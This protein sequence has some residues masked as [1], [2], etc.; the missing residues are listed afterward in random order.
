M[1]WYAY[2]AGDY[3]QSVAYLQ[4]AFARRPA[5]Q[6]VG[7][8]LGYAYEALGAHEIENFVAT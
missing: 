7:L 5:D 2:Q 8:R 3:A 1:G 4:K 6:L